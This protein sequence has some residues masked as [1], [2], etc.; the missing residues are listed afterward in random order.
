MPGQA[1]HTPNRHR[2]PSGQGTSHLEL[3]CKP[4]LRPLPPRNRHCTTRRR[5]AGLLE[6]AGKQQQRPV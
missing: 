3:A 6:R 5:E 1:Q 2:T 4:I